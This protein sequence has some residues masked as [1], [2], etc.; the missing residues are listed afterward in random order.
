MP[1]HQCG[2][3]EPSLSLPHS[4]LPSLYL[5]TMSADEPIVA[6]GALLHGHHRP[7]SLCLLYSTT[8]SVSP[9]PLLPPPHPA[10]PR[11]WQGHK[12]PCPAELPQPYSGC[13]LDA[14]LGHHCGPQTTQSP[15][16]G[17]RKPRQALASLCLTVDAT[18]YHC[19]SGRSPTP[20]C[21][22]GQEGTGHHRLR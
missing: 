20:P 22:C 1:L 8:T 13:H 2:V 18:V 6:T 21:S 16:T 9:P 17:V 7:A 5:L 19:R 14:W 4:L 15:S 10:F 12:R 3:P 11:H